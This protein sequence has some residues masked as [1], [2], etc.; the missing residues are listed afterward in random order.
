VAN[1]KLIPIYNIEYL[2]QGI[3]QILRVI[4]ARL[5]HVGFSAASASDGSGK[6]FYYV[7]CMEFFA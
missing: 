1:K 4:S 7:P 3:V 6:L 5:S 2:S